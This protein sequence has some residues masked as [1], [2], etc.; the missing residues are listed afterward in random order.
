MPE[1][2]SL[3]VNAFVQT[4][5]S[6]LAGAVPS[7]DADGNGKL[8]RGESKAL[9]R[10]F[11]DDFDRI[12]GGGAVD[13]GELVAQFRATLEASA[14]GADRNGDGNLDGVEAERLEPE[15]QDNYWKMVATNGRPG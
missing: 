10:Q 1:A 12:G 11:H 15:L 8:S 13:N 14:T 2:P 3:N 4:S 5:V 6:T 9:P 7:A